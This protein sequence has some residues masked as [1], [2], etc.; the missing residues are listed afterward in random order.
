MAEAAIP[1]ETWRAYIMGFEDRSDYWLTDQQCL[2]FM[3]RCQGVDQD[4]EKNI[5]R[6]SF[7]S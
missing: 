1:Y 5:S 2:T 6:R 4:E 7:L 3:Q